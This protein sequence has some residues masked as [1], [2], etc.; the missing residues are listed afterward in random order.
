MDQP[1]LKMELKYCERCGGLWLRPGGAAEVY[2]P[3]CADAFARAD[4][5]FAPRPLRRGRPQ[6]V[7]TTDP[8]TERSA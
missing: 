8:E 5:A 6:S 3:A 2:C 7:V 1:I 4:A